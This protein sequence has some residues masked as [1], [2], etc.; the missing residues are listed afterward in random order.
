MIEEAVYE[1]LKKDF[2]QADSYGKKQAELVQEYKK[3]VERLKSQQVRLLNM[4][5]EL[6]EVITNQQVILVEEYRGQ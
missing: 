4:N 2:E 5:A 6:I 3:R 1:K